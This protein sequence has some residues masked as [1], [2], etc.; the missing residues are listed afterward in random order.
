MK[1]SSGI[2]VLHVLHCCYGQFGS[3]THNLLGRSHCFSHTPDRILDDFR[4]G[5]VQHLPFVTLKG[6]IAAVSIDDLLSRTLMKLMSIQLD[7]NPWKAI[8]T[9]F[10]LEAMAFSCELKIETV[11]RISDNHYLLWDW[12][13]VVNRKPPTV[14]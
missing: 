14:F 8:S 5:K 13:P 4:T 1:R 3:P 6:P 10:A 12:V 11:R 9:E 7:R 2:F